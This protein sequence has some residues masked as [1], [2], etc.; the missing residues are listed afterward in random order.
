MLS[1][2][3]RLKKKEVSFL[4]DKGEKRKSHFF[5]IILRKNRKNLCRFCIITGK[6]LKLKPVE[7][8][9]LRRQIYSAINKNWTAIK[10]DTS[11]DVALIPYQ[12]INGKSFAEIS[13]EITYILDNL[14]KWEK[15]Y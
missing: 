8:I 2:S 9:R 10:P 11:L 1:K 7:R 5:S 3:K 15:T 4:L 13:K 14:N 12:Q 6:S